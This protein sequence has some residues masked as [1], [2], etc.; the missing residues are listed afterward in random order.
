[1]N[2]KIY[3]S[4]QSVNLSLEKLIEI[5]RN[6]GID[7]IIYKALSPN[8][9][10]K[11]QLYIAGHFTDIGYIPTK[12]LIPSL[13]T[14][15]KTSDPKRQVKFTADLN[16]NWVSPEGQCYLAPTAKLIYY[17]QFPEVRLSGFLLRCP[18]DM[19]GWMDPTK[20]GRS[21]GRVMFLGTREDGSIFAY[22]AIPG[23]RIAKEVLEQKSYFLSSVLQELPYSK[24]V[25]FMKQGELKLK[26]KK[27]TYDVD[28]NENLS[29][30]RNE[31][32]R[33]LLLSEL[34][35]IHLSG[36]INSKK[37]NAKGIPVEYRARNGGGYTL[38]AELGVIPN[39]VAEPDFHGWEIKQFG[40][41]RF[42]LIGSKALTLMTPEPDGGVYKDEG[43][44]PF[45]YRYGYQNEKILD[46]Y[47]FTG[48]HFAETMC[49]KSGLTLVLPGFNAE[50]G[51]MIDANGC[52]GL[53]D[54][55]ENIAASWSYS[56][57]L[58]HW[59]KK[60][61]RAAYIPSV[62]SDNS[63]GRR[64]Y[65]Y[66]NIVRLYE[67]TNINLLL[68]AVSDKLMYYDPGIKMENASTH[69]KVKKRSQF[70]IKS[71]DLMRLYKKL[72]TVDVTKA[73]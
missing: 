73:D 7:R 58:E 5:Y 26:D 37:L 9:N 12:E 49:E 15:N 23:S 11:N 35:R 31:K 24:Y 10:S 67:G 55:N 50:S 63:G 16:L 69:P 47:D 53:M 57:L 14:S 3:D 71:K 34:R 51:M 19:G 70:R 40:V 25:A 43:I 21:P 65:H 33:I 4:N 6:L 62:S 48:R 36:P 46:R 44:Q 72:E 27:E 29:L 68:G 32:A 39:G 60:H 45:I 17:P 42:D 59:K 54:K 30:D 22:L 66:G 13:S 64:A 28:K 38:E 61:A 56:K 20:L 41:N 8:D 18:I 2:P 52:I 1:M